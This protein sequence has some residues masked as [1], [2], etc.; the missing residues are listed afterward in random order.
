MKWISRPKRSSK[1]DSAG[2]PIH[3]REMFAAERVRP[4]FTTA[5]KHTPRGSVLPV[6]W[7]S[8]AR[9]SSVASRMSAGRP[10]SGVATFLRS[11]TSWPVSRSTIAPLMPVPPMSMPIAWS[12]AIAPHYRGLHERRSGKSEDVRTALGH[13]EGV[14]ELGGEGAIAGDDGPVVAPELPLDRAEGEHRLDREHHAGFQHRVEVGIV[15]VGDDEARVEHAADAVP[16][17]VAHDAVAESLRI[18]LDR[19]PDDVHLTTGSDGADAPG[20]RFPRALHEQLHVLAR[21]AHHEGLVEVAVEPVEVGRHVE[22]HEV[23]VFEHRVIG[24]P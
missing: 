16:G 21:V 22:V 12:V 8:S 13:H 6:A 3:S 17:V 19:A 20:E 7:S 2:R 24:D 4:C 5:G 23:A 14:L 1:S 18:R 11:E 10:P 9:S 15:V